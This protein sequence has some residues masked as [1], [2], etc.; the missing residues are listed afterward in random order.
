MNI[1]TLGDSRNLIITLKRNGLVSS[2]IGSTMTASFINYA[3]KIVRSSVV[4]GLVTDPGAN[5]A[6]G[7]AAFYFAGAQISNI[8]ND[9]ILKLRVKV[10]IGS[11]LITFYSVSDYKFISDAT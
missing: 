2:Y 4:T 5:W 10:T 11:E 7:I 1:Y 9:E 8:T 3:R 6:Q